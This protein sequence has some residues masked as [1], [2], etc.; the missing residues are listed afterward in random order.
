MK[1]K[2]KELKHLT[3]IFKFWRK[4]VNFPSLLLYCLN[5]NRSGG[6]I[7]NDTHC[8]RASVKPGHDM[9]IVPRLKYHPEY[10]EFEMWLE[11]A[12]SQTNFFAYL[13]HNDCT[14]D[15]GVP[16]T[17]RIGIKSYRQEL[18]KHPLTY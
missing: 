7:L 9:N 12:S 11:F 4:S 6:S 16:K 17:T 8:L 15:V 5:G 1:Y 14:S 3:C 13:S 18:F 10:S 2:F